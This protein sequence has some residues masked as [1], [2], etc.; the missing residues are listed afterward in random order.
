MAWLVYA[1]FHA[2][3]QDK[4]LAAKRIFQNGQAC[5]LLVCRDDGFE[6]P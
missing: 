2:C 6:E 1:H 3:V 5:K 4:G